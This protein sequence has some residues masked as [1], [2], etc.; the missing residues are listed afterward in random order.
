MHSWCIFVASLKLLKEKQK[1]LWKTYERLEG[2]EL[3]VMKGQLSEWQASDLDGG[4]RV[5]CCGA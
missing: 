4:S 1:L 2:E 5:D 3:E